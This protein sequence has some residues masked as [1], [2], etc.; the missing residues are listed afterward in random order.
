[1]I[2]HALIVEKFQRFF[3]HQGSIFNVYQCPLN[4]CIFNN[5]TD[6]DDSIFMFKCT[7]PGT[8]VIKSVI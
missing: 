1:M 6:A 2:F 3:M 8:C 4:I 5:R 7:Y